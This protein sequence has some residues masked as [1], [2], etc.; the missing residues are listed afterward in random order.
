[1]EKCIF[2]SCTPFSF[3]HYHTPQHIIKFFYIAISG[4]MY[5]TTGQNSKFKTILPLTKFLNSKIYLHFHFFMVSSYSNMKRQYRFLPLPFIPN[6]IPLASFIS[7]FPQ[8]RHMW[9]LCIFLGQ[10]SVV[11]IIHFRLPPNGLGICN[12]VAPTTTSTNSHH[13]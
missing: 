10:F 2:F 9:S 12:T 8:T 4:L 13:Q 11:T 1:M 6:S 5:F 3:S 7:L